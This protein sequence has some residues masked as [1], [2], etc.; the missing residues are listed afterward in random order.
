MTLNALSLWQYAR[1][2]TLVRWTAYLS[3]L[4]SVPEYTAQRTAVIQPNVLLSSSPA[5]WHHP[6]IAKEGVPSDG[7]RLLSWMLSHAA[8]QA[9]L[10]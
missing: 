10:L 7:G 6:Y 4:L 8:V 3:T 5:Y 9:R 1:G 2:R